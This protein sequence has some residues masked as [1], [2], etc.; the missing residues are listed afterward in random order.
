MNEHSHSERR[1]ILVRITLLV[2]AI[3]L[4]SG[5]LVVALIPGWQERG[6]FGDLFGA[7]NALFS[8]LA[9]AGVVYAILLQQE[10]LSLQ[11]EEMER[12]ARAGELS[13]RLTAISQL[14]AHNRER[15]REVSE[16]MREFER[17]QTPSK[18]EKAAHPMNAKECDELN[19]QWSEWH[20]DLKSVYKELRALGAS[21]KLTPA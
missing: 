6:Q 11:R 19:W 17:N 14:I 5:F 1:R 9:L 2:L 4:G 20:T 13:A 7:V 12:V 15:Y 16:Q 8:G 10:E 21:S 18:F 3:W